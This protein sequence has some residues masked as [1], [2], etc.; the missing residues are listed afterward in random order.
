MG[1]LSL[2]QGGNGGSKRYTEQTSVVSQVRSL[3]WQL[4]H[5]NLPLNIHRHIQEHHNVSSKCTLCLRFNETDEHL[6]CQCDYA[7]AVWANVRKILEVMKLNTIWSSSTASILLGKVSAPSA[8]SHYQWIDPEDPPSATALTHYV[9]KIW[10]ELR[11]VA[12]NC[13]WTTR[14][15]FR[16]EHK[17]RTHPHVLQYL[18]GRLWVSYRVV[19]VGKLHPRDSPKIRSNLMIFEHTCW[20]RVKDLILTRL[21]ISNLKG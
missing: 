4:Y 3:M 5:R 9:T 2:R 18:V 13:I 10:A 20:T 17:I 8:L 16:T 12:L 6:F 19:A 15:E 7:T 14:N 11:G 21:N 1:K